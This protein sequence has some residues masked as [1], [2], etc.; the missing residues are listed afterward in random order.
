MLNEELFKKIRY[1]ELNVKKKVDNYLQGSYH[2]LFK[3]QGLE[4]QEVREYT[5]NDDARLIDWNVTARTGKPFVKVFRE[6]RE[7]TV[8][9]AA[10]IS[11]STLYGKSSGLREVMATIAAAISFSAIK[12]S[13]KVGLLLF[14]DRIEEY[15]PPR[16]GRNH[17]LTVIRALLTATPKGRKTDPEVPFKFLNKVMKRKTLTFFLSDMM[18]DKLPESLNITASKHEIVPVGVIDETIFTPLVQG[19]VKVLDPETGETSILDL[20]IPGLND[21]TK[22]IAAHEA[23][24]KRKGIRPVWIMNREN[25]MDELV[26]EFKKLSSVRKK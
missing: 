4:F 3:G 9:I 16:R 12:N 21:M 17:L 24:F 20:S 1:I 26:N 14:S 18:F 11:G 22:F 10:D 19:A 7:L 25:F 23:G 5:E 2:T 8:M 15:I 6:E 13:D